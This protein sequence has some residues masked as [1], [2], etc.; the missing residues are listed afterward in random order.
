MPSTAKPAARV[1]DPH[2][3]P[4]T[5]FGMPHVGGPIL[6]PGSADVS[7][8]KAPA[9]RQEDRAKCEAGPPARIVAGS[10]SVTI[11]GRPAARQGDATEH[12][13]AIGAGAGTVTIGD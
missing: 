6:P 3:C 2:A 4:S 13:G 10:G 7:I 8:E 1:T 5:D 11:N 9:A 12:G